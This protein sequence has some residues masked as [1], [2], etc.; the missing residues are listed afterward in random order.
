MCLSPCVINH[1]VLFGRYH[2]SVSI[3]QSLELAFYGFPSTESTATAI[4]ACSTRLES[5]EKNPERTEP[6]C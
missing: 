3:C 1:R 5:A 4:I 2:G 6:A